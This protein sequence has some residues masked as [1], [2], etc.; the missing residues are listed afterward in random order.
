MQR[1][2]L[3]IIILYVLHVPHQI[4]SSEYEVLV[5]FAADVGEHNYR[6]EIENGEEAKT[7]CEPSAVDQRGS[8]QCWPLFGDLASCVL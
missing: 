8:L 4:E 6:Y 5:P 2:Q 7:G 1:G 3:R